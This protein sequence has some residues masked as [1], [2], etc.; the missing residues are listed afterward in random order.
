MNSQWAKG[1]SEEVNFWIQWLETGGLKWPQEFQYRTDPRAEIGGVA[2]Q[3][4]QKLPENARVL[5]VGAG[6]MTAL[7][8]MLDGRPI[9]I[10]A[11]DALA[12]LYDKL[13][14]PPGSPIIRTRKCDTERLTEEFGENMFDLTYAQNTLDHSYDPMTALLQMVAVTKPGGYIATCHTANEAV[15]QNWVGLHQW[16]FHIESRD[17]KISSKHD[18]YSVSEAVAGKAPIVELAPDG[19]SW[20]VCVLRK[21]PF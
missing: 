8:K 12:D 15:T 9:D 10:T 19:A 3:Y 5:D 20:V 13:P 7:G 18:T 6:P 2:R 1:H 21:L 16:N 4:L 11:V 14:F 17:L